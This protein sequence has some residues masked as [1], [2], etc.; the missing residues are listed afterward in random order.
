MKIVKLCDV[1]PLLTLSEIENYDPENIIA[2]KFLDL[3]LD[4]QNQ[5]IEKN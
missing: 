2:E 1:I 3:S 5:T 4:N